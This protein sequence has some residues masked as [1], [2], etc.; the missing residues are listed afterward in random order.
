MF[1]SRLWLTVCLGI[2][3]FLW[4][5]SGMTPSASGLSKPLFQPASEDI[6]RLAMITHQLDMKASHCIEL[7]DCEQVYFERALVS[8]FENQ[9]AAR[10]SFR[11][12]IEHNGASPLA[13]SSQLWLRVIGDDEETG[14][15]IDERSS[16]STGLLAQFVRDWM[17][18]Q[19]AE[20]RF[21]EKA[22]ALA[23]IQ[24][25]VEDQ[26]RLLQAIQKQVRSR[27]RQ[28]AILRSQLDALKLIDEEGQEKQR[29]IKPPASLRPAE[30]HQGQ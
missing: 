8:L 25:T 16:A 28:I 26:S 6:P 21:D 4:G 10:A 14:K 20:P 29:K 12:V 1:K 3:S 15:L 7:A 13:S 19:V 24:D 17:E 22:M 9:E 11:H 2:V 30:Y 5:C 18:R 23:T 27:D